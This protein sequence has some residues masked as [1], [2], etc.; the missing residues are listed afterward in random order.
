MML[1]ILMKSTKEESINNF[2]F[3]KMP[4]FLSL[5]DEH[6]KLCNSNNNF[7]DNNKECQYLMSENI[8]DYSI[9]RKLIEAS[10]LPLRLM[11]NNVSNE[12]IV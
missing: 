6:Q 2:D 4:D 10:K 9:K 7:E 8:K 3:D 5:F 11:M 12:L 1:L